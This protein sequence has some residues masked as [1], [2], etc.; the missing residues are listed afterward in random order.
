MNFCKTCGSLITDEC[1]NVK[2]PEK[3]AISRLWIVEGTLY[4]FRREITLDEAREA[5]D[6]NSSIIL[7]YKADKDG[8]NKRD[9]QGIYYNRKNRLYRDAGIL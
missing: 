2:C 1:T 9:M 4:R 6:K 5:V 7:A 3:N 8:Q